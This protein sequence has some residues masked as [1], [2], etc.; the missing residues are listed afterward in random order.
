MRSPRGCTSHPAP[1]KGDPCRRTP[2]R[3]ARMHRCSRFAQTHIFLA[4]RGAKSARNG[5]D[6]E[7]G[8]GQTG[9]ATDRPRAHARAF[10]VDGR[11]TRRRAPS[12]KRREACE[13]HAERRADG[14]LPSAG[15]P[16]LFSRACRLGSCTQHDVFLAEKGG[17]PARN[18]R[19]R[20]RGAASRRHRS[21]RPRH[22]GVRSLL[23]RGSAPG[24]WRRHV[25]ADSPVPRSP[26]GEKCEERA[27]L[28]GRG[29]VRRATPST[30]RG[31]ARTCRCRR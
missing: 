14:G 27:S 9:S 20:E 16:R 19:R 28:R 26:V 24:A 21:S 18:A 11:R 13:E 2:G 7:L 23:T 15:L 6:C 4:R 25:P 30:R 10:R 5:R 31:A 12:L 17:H 1:R 22:L 29:G 3:F 8:S